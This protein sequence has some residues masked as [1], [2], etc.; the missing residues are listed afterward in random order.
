[1]AGDRREYMRNWYH[2]NKHRFAEVYRERRRVWYAA[3]RERVNTERRAMGENRGYR[4]RRAYM[5]QWWAELK[6]TDP[7]R[8]A[9]YMERSNKRRAI[10]PLDPTDVAIHDART[11][12]FDYRVWQREQGSA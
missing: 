7:T 10:R 11:V 8:Y 1:M 6:D 9:K 3:N 12:L 4:D 2:R 5:R